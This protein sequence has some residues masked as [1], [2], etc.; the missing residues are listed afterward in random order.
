VTEEASVVERCI[1]GSKRSNQGRVKMEGCR[2][3]RRAKRR[4]SYSCHYCACLCV[5]V[6]VCVCLRSTSPFLQGTFCAP[7]MCPHQGMPAF[8]LGDLWLYQL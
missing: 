4:I 2:V 5:C 6:C 7:T 8:L 1:Q 3:L